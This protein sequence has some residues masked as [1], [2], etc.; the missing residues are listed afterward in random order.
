[1]F[2][3][4]ASFTREDT[5]YDFFNDLYSNY[6][7][8]NQLHE[9][10]R[11]LPGFLGIDEEVYRDEFRCDKALCFENEE[12]FNLFVAKNQELLFYRKQIIEE[13]CQRTGHVY[14]YYMIK[15]EDNQ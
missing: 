4:V 6:E 8:V 11:S 10:A 15:N 9:S 2:K 14:K 13:Y 3:V 12:A 1:M 5:K 7:V